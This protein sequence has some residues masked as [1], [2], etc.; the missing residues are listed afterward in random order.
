MRSPAPWISAVPHPRYQVSAR[1]ARLRT[2]RIHAALAREELTALIAAH[3]ELEAR[4]TSV[5]GRL[6]A[7]DRA[8]RFDE[9]DMLL[10]DPDTAGDGV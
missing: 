3:P 1:V 4:L 7:L 6:D 8:M 9:E 5:A 2:A 10:A